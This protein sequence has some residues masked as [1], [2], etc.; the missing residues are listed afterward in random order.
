MQP[1]QITPRTPLA[2]SVDTPHSPGKEPLS[3]VGIGR[4]QLMH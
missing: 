4:R 1:G 2:S 3:T